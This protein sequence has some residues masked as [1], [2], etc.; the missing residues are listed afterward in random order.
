LI[1][2]DWGWQDSWAEG[3]INRLPQGV[4]F[5]SVSEWS[6]PIERGGVKSVVGEYS[7]STIG[8]GPRASRHWNFARKRGLKTFAKIQAGN[9]WELSATPYIPALENVAQHAVNLRRAKVDGLMLG[10]TLGGYPSP[11][12]EVVSEIGQNSDVTAEEAMEKVASRRF[13]APL[14]PAVVKAWR[15]FSKAFREFPFGTGLYVTPMQVGPSNLFWTKRTGYA[16]TMVGFPYDD[17]EGWRRSYPPDVFI[18][19]FEKISAGFEEALRELKTAAEGQKFTTTQKRAFARELSVAEAAAIHFR[20]TTNQCQFIQARQALTEAKTTADRKAPLSQIKEILEKEITLA[21][22]LHTIQNQDSRI[23]F[24][25]SNQYYY[26]P[27]DL[28]E[29]VLN[30][31]DLLNRWLPEQQ[32]GG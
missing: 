30:C 17:F 1:A 28:A 25:A 4:G 2:W 22:R 23:G 3:I 10:W 19:Q 29:K 6:I 13:G 9:T 27:V 26:T 31:E 20:T 11:N 7:I 8:P 14:A 32:K 12:L 5:M 18:G 24:E 16:A 15:E 21:S